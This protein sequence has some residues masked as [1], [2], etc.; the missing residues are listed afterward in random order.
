M[1]LP[2]MRSARI[3]AVI[4][5]NNLFTVKAFFP[6]NFIGHGLRHV[7]SEQQHCKSPAGPCQMVRV[8]PEA[9]CATMFLTPAA[10]SGL[11]S[12]PPRAG[13]QGM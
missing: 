8:H 4:L 2:A 9:I 12:I 7:P 6:L 10:E 1:T 5:V 11:V 3:I 13:R